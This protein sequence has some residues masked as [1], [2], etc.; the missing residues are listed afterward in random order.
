M[1]VVLDIVPNHMAT[2][3]ANRFWADRTL[4][5]KFFDLDEKTGRHRRFFDVDHL[6]ALRQEDPEVFAA[7]HELALRLV[8]RGVVDGLRIDHPD[9]LADPA[10]LSGAAARSRRR[11]RVGGED[12]RPRRAPARLAGRRHRRLRVPQRRLRA[13]RRSGGRGA[14]DRPVG[15]GLR[16]RP[17]L[18]RLGVRGQARAGADDV[19]A[20]GRAAA[21]RRAGARGRPGARAGVAPGL[22]HLRR[23]VVGEGQRRGSRGCRRGAAARVVRRPAA[24]R[25][26]RLGGVRHPLPAD[27]AARDGQGRR[28]HGVLPLRAAARA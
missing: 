24:A 16:R 18:L 22:P 19:R 20:G 11:A 27:D 9:G 25:G 10:G 3:D 4:R 28:G 21:A 2:D 5:A 17:A 15:G 7:T 1:G 12:P 6:A 23:A 14:A 13:V 26:P 8:N